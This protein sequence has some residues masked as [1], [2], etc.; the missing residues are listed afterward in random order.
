MNSDYKCPMTW[1]QHIANWQRPQYAIDSSVVPDC[2]CMVRGGN[3]FGG[4]SYNLYSGM[5][6]YMPC[7]RN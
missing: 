6:S 1:A 2:P 7:C 5:G 3:M 4:E